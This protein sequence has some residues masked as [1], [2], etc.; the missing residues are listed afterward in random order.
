MRWNSEVGSGLAAGVGSG[1]EVC[2][3]DRAGFSRF[4]Q[5]LDLMAGYSSAEGGNHDGRTSSRVLSAGVG[6]LGS[7]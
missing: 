3:D 2:N 7:V 1:V 6:V 5:V 4:P